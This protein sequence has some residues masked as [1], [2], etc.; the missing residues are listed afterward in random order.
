MP[1]YS[2]RVKCKIRAQMG[3]YPYRNQAGAAR[4]NYLDLIFKTV[5][6]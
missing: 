5:S 4:G 1:R 3:A 6:E 2:I